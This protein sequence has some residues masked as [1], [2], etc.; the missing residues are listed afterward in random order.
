MKKKLDIL[1]A[2]Q[3]KKEDTLLIMSGYFVIKI[4]KTDK[5]V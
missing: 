5:L 1:K 3:S 4:V 2:F